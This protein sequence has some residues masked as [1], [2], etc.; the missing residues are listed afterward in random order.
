MYLLF[1][2]FFSPCTSFLLFPHKQARI[3]TLRR[4]QDVSKTDDAITLLN[5]TLA[6]IFRIEDDDEDSLPQF[7]G[8]IDGLARQ[9]L[10]SLR[11][12][13]IDFLVRFFPKAPG[14]IPR[15][16]EGAK[17]LES[18]LKRLIDE[19]HL[20]AG[21]G[22]SIEITAET[23][24]AMVEVWAMVGVPSRAQEI[25]DA[26]IA[27]N[28]SP[29]IESYTALL[30]AWAGNVTKA[31]AIWDEIMGKKLT[32]VGRTFYRMLDTYARSNPNKRQSLK[33]DVQ[34]CEEIFESMPSYGVKR[35]VHTYMALQKVYARS[36]LA[37]SD[38]KIMEVLERLRDI[39]SAGDEN[40]KPHVMHCNREY[41]FSLPLIFN[42]GFARFWQKFCLSIQER[43]LG[44]LL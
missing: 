7:S 38:Q 36:G 24:A 6:P 43:I 21:K 8:I 12:E 44:R 5:E 10:G 25:H 11:K 34:R 18:I 13:E 42:P 3:S 19:K 9:P 31:E 29:T 16:I 33:K 4:F 40:A 20:Q 1:F 41:D 35:N 30:L 32:P 15:S 22:T 27:H 17:E 2:S 14:W 23:Y 37:G 26:T 28:Y 39:Y